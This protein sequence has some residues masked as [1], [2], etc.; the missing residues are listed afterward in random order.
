M[1]KKFKIN[2]KEYIAKP[3]DFNLVCD[4]E[5]YGFSLEELGTKK[6]KAVRAYFALCAGMSIE[7]AGNEIQAHVVKGGSMEELGNILGEEMEK[8]DFFQAI[9]ANTKQ[10]TPADQE[11]T[12]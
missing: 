9:T 7:E 1:N 10:E 3:F 12:K 4:L 8:S 11:E 6:I 2:E 5:D